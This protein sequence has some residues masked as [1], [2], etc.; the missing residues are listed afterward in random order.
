MSRAVLLL[1]TGFFCHAPVDMVFKS[2]R[3]LS[4]SLTCQII[5]LSVFSRTNESD[6]KD[7]SINLQNTTLKFKGNSEGR[8]YEVDIEFFKPV[9]AQGSTYKV[10]PRSVQM[11]VMKKKADEGEDDEF[12]PRLLKD[13]ALEKNQVKIDWDRY[14]DEDE[15]DGGFDT[16]ALEGG[17]GMGGMGDMMGGMGGLGGM[18]GMGG[19]DMDAL[20]KQMGDMGGGRGD[21]PDSDDESDGDLPDL[22]DA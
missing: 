17:M 1:D 8:D 11:H 16:S 7:E 19:M 13:K 4:S 3:A 2:L 20:M 6:V 21:E 12:W 14:V 15:E 18:G 22:E 10:L 9:D 5:S